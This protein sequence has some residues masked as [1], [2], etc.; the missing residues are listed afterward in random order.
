[1]FSLFFFNFLY[2]RF[3]HTKQKKKKRRRS[4]KWL[5][6]VSLNCRTKIKMQLEKWEQKRKL[7]SSKLI[8]RRKRFLILFDRLFWKRNEIEKED[9]DHLG[10]AWVNGKKKNSKCFIKNKLSSAWDITSVKN[11][12]SNKS[13]R[14]MANTFDVN[15]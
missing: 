2:K 13:R 10:Q 14:K 11:F 8:S 5:I 4:I 7:E 6:L 1:L 12:Q 3:P 9:R 15:Q